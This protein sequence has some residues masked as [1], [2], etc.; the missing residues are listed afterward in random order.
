M[1]NLTELLAL[2]NTIKTETTEGANTASRIGQMYEDVLNN[3]SLSADYRVISGVIRNTGTGWELIGGDHEAINVDSVS[4]NSS[5]IVIDF[6]TLA[7]T[8]IVSFLI[9]PDDDY[10][11][12]YEVGVFG[13]DESDDF[14]R[15]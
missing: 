11:G 4:D 12:L 7:A 6:T 8:K 15:K 10:A 5:T 3:S 14:K 13:E 1:A 9:V 2:A